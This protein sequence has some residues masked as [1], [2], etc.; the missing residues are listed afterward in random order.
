ML[1]SIA[2]PNTPPNSA[3]VSEIADD[4]SIKIIDDVQFAINRAG[5]N[6]SQIFG[7]DFDSA[8]NTYKLNIT[9]HF[10]GMMNG[11][12]S[13]KLMVTVY[14][15]AEHPSRVVLAGPQ[16]SEHP[17]KLNVSFTRF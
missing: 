8:D 7:G 10:Q 6:F 14:N 17:L 4:S 2:I 9:S 15:R 13:K 3:V 5:S 11:S 12:K 1:P 16:H